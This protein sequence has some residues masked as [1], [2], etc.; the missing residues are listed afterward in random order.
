[1]AAVELEDEKMIVL[2][3]VPQHSSVEQLETGMQMDLVIDTL[4][5]D[6]DNEYVVW[7]WRPA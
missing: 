2:G 6:D 4:F 7:K 5:E 3:Q 1:M